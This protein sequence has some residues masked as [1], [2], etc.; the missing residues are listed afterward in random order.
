MVK[1]DQKTGL[2]AIPRSLPIDVRTAGLPVAIADLGEDATF[3]FLEFFTANIRNKNTRSAYARAVWKFFDSCPLALHDITSVHIAAYV[4]KLGE[5]YAPPT[6]K[7]H[8]AALRMLFD[9]LII[10]Q[11]MPTNPAHAVRGPKH[12][13]KKG[14]T[15]ILVKDEI[16]QLFDSIDATTSVGLRDRAM[17][18]T[19]FYTFGRV[20]AVVGL[21]R[22]DVYTQRRKTWLRF[23]EKGGKVHEAP[24]HHLLDEYLLDY[25]EHSPIS[26]FTEPKSPLF[27]SIARGR[28]GD[29]TGRRLLRGEAYKMVRRRLRQADIDTV[30]GN[31][32]FRASGITIYLENGGQVEHAQQMAG[33]ESPRTTKLYDRRND[34]ISLDEVEKIII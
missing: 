4:E 2:P 14:K 10:G 6:V 7:Q 24:C 28:G 29:F 5:E 22:E 17:I 16:K 8:L 12:V 23:R 3:R 33:H 34:I 20:S 19:L 9:F 21:N 11:I 13:V 30:A 25:L 15:P 1:V 32:M 27:C 31:H 26:G 18:A